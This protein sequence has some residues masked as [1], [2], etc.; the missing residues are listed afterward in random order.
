V[1]RKLARASPVLLLDLLLLA[2]YMTTTLEWVGAGGFGSE[3]VRRL[4]YA[5]VPLVFTVGYLACGRKRLARLLLA[6]AWVSALLSYA[7]A[8]GP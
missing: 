7:A 2:I 5:T 4:T 3:V 1:T 6:L 8:A